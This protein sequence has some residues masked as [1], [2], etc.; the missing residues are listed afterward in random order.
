M[1]RDPPGSTRTD[2]LFPYTALV[3]AGPGLRLLRLSHGTGLHAEAAGRPLPRARLRFTA[4]RSQGVAR[5]APS[6]AA[7]LG[8]L[9]PFLRR[10]R[11]SVRTRPHA[12]RRPLSVRCP[13]PPRPTSDRPEARPSGPAPRPPC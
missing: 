3:R 9:P 2:T 11:L 12:A 1:I 7:A 10:L 8:R 5:R 6:G 13:A 4:L